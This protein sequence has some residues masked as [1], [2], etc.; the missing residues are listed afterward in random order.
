MEFA[1]ALSITLALAQAA[2]ATAET[3]NVVTEE[4]LNEA[5]EM[6][7]ERVRSLQSKPAAPKVPK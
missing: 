4:K 7:A 5:L 6:V 2:R 1:E 3:G